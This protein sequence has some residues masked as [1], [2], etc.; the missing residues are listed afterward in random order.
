M[1]TYLYKCLACGHEFEE[2]MRLSDHEHKTEVRCPKCQSTKVQ[3]E[4]TSFNAVTEHK[5]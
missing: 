1:P 5:T 3:Q 4:P 2:T